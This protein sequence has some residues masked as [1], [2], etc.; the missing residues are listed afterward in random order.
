MQNILMIR[1]N[2]EIESCTHSVTFISELWHWTIIFA[3]KEECKEA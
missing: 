3:E 1:D 2:N